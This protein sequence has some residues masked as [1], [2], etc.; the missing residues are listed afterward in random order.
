MTNCQKE[1][2]KIKLVPVSFVF[3]E[4]ITFVS[5][6][7]YLPTYHVVLLHVYKICIL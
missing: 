6:S 3:R 4:G 1:S 7:N 2:P 5:W